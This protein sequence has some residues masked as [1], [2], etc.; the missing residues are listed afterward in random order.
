MLFN[1]SDVLFS[2]IENIRKYEINGFIVFVSTK[3]GLCYSS[4]WNILFKFSGDMHRHLPMPA[5]REI[6]DH[7]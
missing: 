4:F 3:V 1:L 5:S 2:S 7:F 6:H